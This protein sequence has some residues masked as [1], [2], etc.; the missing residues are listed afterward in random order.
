MIDR[1]EQQ[2]DYIYWD[3]PNKLVARS[4]LLLATQ[5]AGNPSLKMELF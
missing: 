4:R 1:K 5:A 3:G 2:S